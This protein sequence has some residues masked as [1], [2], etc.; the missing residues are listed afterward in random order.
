MSD[1][2]QHV[3][4][5]RLAERIA[6]SFPTDPIP[7]YPPD[8]GLDPPGEKDEYAAFAYTAWDK[9]PLENFDTFGGFDISP[10]VG[11]SLHKPP[12][13][14]NF[15]VPGFMTASLLHADDCEATDGFMWRLREF[16]PGP[17]GYAQGLPWWHGNRLFELYDR[18]QTQCVVD[19]LEFIRTH[20]HKSP[21]EFDWEPT[22]ELTLQRWL[23]RSMH[24][25]MQ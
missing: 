8:M 6:T 22:D 1:D 20:G 25:E 16:D 9:V 11:F 2:L 17:P 7:E 5:R 4:A 15:H 14:W 23:M 3:E 18:D 10:V 24:F 19:Y 21:R 12:H 13:M